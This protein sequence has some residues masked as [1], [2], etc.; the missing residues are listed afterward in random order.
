MTV[1]VGTVVLV[2]EVT[3]KNEVLVIVR[4]S[5]SVIVSV[6]KE[7]SVVN[8]VLVWVVLT[9]LIVNGPVG[10]VDVVTMGAAL[11]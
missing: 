5:S 9:V 3:G 7:V 8:W 6:I 4:I 2:V 1:V 11:S 10:M